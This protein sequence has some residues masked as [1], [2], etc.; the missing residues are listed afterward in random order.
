VSLAEE[1]RRLA[2]SA[3]ALKATQERQSRCAERQASDAFVS[4][5]V[6]T[7]IH[8]F[9]FTNLDQALTLRSM[10][11]AESSCTLS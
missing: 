9:R 8:R 1:L 11:I 2:H 6:A 10:R 3:V 4:T 5:S 7:V